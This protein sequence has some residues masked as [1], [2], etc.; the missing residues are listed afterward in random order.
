[1]VSAILYQWPSLPESKLATVSALAAEVVEP[2]L[3]A[4]PPHSTIARARNVSTEIPLTIIF[5]LHSIIVTEAGLEEDHHNRRCALRVRS[6]FSLTAD[7][8]RRHLLIRE[9]FDHSQ[10]LSRLLFL[11][12]LSQDYCRG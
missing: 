12:K 7:E 8:F 3:N 11:L 6:L 1:M 5:L 9:L 2:E 4:R 10:E